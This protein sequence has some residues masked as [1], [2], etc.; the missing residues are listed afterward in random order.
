MTKFRVRVGNQ[1]VSESPYNPYLESQSIHHKKK[2]SAATLHFVPPKAI[3]QM[4]FVCQMTK[5]SYHRD[6]LI[7][8]LQNRET[9]T[10]CFRIVFAKRKSATY[11]CS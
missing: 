6:L 5:I 7:F 3:A 8:Y 10:I 4:C 9:Q 1:S 11:V 2:L